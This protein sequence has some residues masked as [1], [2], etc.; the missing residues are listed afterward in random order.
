MDIKCWLTELKRIKKRSEESFTV[1]ILKP[2]RSLPFQLESHCLKYLKNVSATIYV[3]VITTSSESINSARGSA[4]INQEN[5]HSGIN[6]EENFLPSCSSH[7][8]FS[9]VCP[10]AEGQQR[11]KASPLSLCSACCLSTPVCCL[12]KHEHYVCCDCITSAAWPASLCS[13]AVWR[14]K[15]LGPVL[16]NMFTIL[17][18]SDGLCHQICKHRR[19]VKWMCT[20]TC[21]RSHTQSYTGTVKFSLLFKTC[22]FDT[23]NLQEE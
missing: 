8:W 3:I 9:L 14:F 1:L 10:R 21:T 12:V 17:P 13:A 5:W 18:K 7:P 23:F 20:Y 2:D 22:S 19:M 15:D 11:C 4:K 16:R 6:S